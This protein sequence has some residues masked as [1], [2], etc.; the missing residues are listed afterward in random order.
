MFS[1]S[2]PFGLH[3]CQMGSGVQKQRRFIVCPSLNVQRHFGH[4]Q[5]VSQFSCSFYWLIVIQALERK[6][7]GILHDSQ[8]TFLSSYCKILNSPQDMLDM[9][10]GRK[11]T[12]LKIVCME[13]DTTVI[14][15]FPNEN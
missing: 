15:L 7:K 6:K 9:K 3:R 10:N 11:A 14:N 1:F 2:P 12:Q 8:Q 13:R 4:R 5:S